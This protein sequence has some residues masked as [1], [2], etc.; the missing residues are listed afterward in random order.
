[1]CG[2]SSIWVF[3]RSSHHDLKLQA[4]NVTQRLGKPLSILASLS[5]IQ[6][7]TIC[8]LQEVPASF[9]PSCPRQTALELVYTEENTTEETGNEPRCHSEGK[10]TFLF[11]CELMK[12]K[13]Q[14]VLFESEPAL[15]P[16]D[17]RFSGKWRILCRTRRV[18]RKSCTAIKT[19]M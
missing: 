9:L 19:S 1:M 16:I 13:P 14:S 12:A 11:I 5:Q 15:E 18:R 8:A 10:F 7:T 4:R 6:P 3:Q 17:K 2:K